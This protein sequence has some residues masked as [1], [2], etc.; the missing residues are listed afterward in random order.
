[1]IYLF[2]E[3]MIEIGAI[4][5]NDMKTSR[6]FHIDSRESVGD[7]GWTDELHPTPVHF[8]KI[9]ETFIDCIKQNKLPT[10]SNVYV[11]KNAIHE[12]I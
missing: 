10:Y 3:M 9:G 4:F 12:I 2:N 11:V 6:V 7:N 1:M 5:N 8:M